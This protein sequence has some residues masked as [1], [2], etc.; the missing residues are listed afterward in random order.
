MSEEIKIIPAATMNNSR[1]NWRFAQPQ[2]NNQIIA[3]C[4]RINRDKQESSFDSDL[5]LRRDPTNTRQNC[6]R[7]RW[8]AP[9]AWMVPP[10][11]PRH[12]NLNTGL[13]VS[14]DLL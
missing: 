6:Q 11:P 8:A 14:S 5:A 1:P 3:R 10:T 13:L 4:F 12:L 9:A 7:R 2:I